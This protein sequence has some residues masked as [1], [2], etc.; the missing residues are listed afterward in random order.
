[1]LEID[2]E[3][4]RSLGN[5]ELHQFVYDLGLVGEAATPSQVL[6]AVEASRLDPSHARG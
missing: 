3:A 6:R 4:L 1:L 5:Q 2:R